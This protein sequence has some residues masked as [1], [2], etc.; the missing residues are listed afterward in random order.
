LPALDGA[1]FFRSLHGGGRAGTGSATSAIT[2]A[3]V[4]V[5][6][7]GFILV[8]RRWTFSQG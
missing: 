8:L 4:I 6:V 7:A 2:L 5:E 1:V 3:R